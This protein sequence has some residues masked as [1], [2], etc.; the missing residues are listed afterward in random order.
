MMASSLVS[1]G[2]TSLLLT[3]ICLLAASAAARPGVPF[4]PCNTLF[5]TYTFSATDAALPG[6]HR[7]SGSLSI[8]RI[9]TSAR[10]SDADPRPTMIPR[11]GFLLPHH[12]VAP[13][14]P[15]SV[16][17]SSLQERAKDILV[18]VI[19]LIFGVGCGALTASTMYLVWSLVAHRHEISGSDA[20]IDEDDVDEN[21]K[22]AGYVEI[23]ATDSVSSAAKEGYEAN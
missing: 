6:D 3:V 16:G 18:V 2:S 5:I 15:A 10:T 20:Y 13:A 23:P 9:I 21:P 17:F 7:V 14:E 19:G 12:E 11:A 4:H 8:Y 1:G 22:K